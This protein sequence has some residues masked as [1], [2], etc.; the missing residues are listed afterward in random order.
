MSEQEEKIY[1][2]IVAAGSGRRFGSQLPKQFCDLGGR[3]VLM[4][5]IE[6]MHQALNEPSEI[7]LVLSDGF[8]DYWSELCTRYGFDSPRIVIGGDT[9]WQS[10]RN[11][12][13]LIPPG[14]SPVFVHDG[15]RPLVDA[16][17]VSRL[18]EALSGGVHGALPVMPV[19]DSLRQWLADGSSIAVDR[20]AYCAVQTPQLFT[21]DILKQA[22]EMPYSP[23]MTDDASVVEMCGYGDIALVDG[24]EYTL[25]ITRK[26]DLDTVA[27]MLGC[28]HK[29]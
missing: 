21:A 1:C 25:K 22:Y 4:T 24:S 14:K 7:F 3:P 28:D 26:I 2:I 8:V 10:V 11:A 27:C 15:A 9:R 13:D 5:T 16:G 18:L 19:A 12:L 20:S 29:S 23:L 17:V 6:R